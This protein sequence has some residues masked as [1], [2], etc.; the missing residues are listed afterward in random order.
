MYFTILRF[1]KQTSSNVSS[2][3][4]HD[5][6]RTETGQLA[7]LTF[8][9]VHLPPDLVMPI[10]Y[11]CRCKQVPC[12]CERPTREVSPRLVTQNP[13]PAVKLDLDLIL[14]DFIGA[15]NSGVIYA[16]SL[17]DSQTVTGAQFA[18]KFPGHYRNKNLLREAWFYDEL[19]SLQGATVPRSYGYFHAMLPASWT[20]VPWQG[21]KH[22]DAELADEAF[23][24]LGGFNV[25]Y[26]PVSTRFETG[27][28]LGVLLLERVDEEY[29][30]ASGEP[31]PDGVM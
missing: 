12:N 19:Q 25:S 4:I 9:R 17:A 18:L 11:G 26:R 7:A 21:L 8:K 27:H 23:E 10:V 29:L 14:D 1:D 28:C 22:N 30:E 24:P 15:Q 20:V 13:P 5:V 6:A 16:T 3:T 2:L 31:M